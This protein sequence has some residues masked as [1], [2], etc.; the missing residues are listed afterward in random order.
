VSWS[1]R[2]RHRRVTTHDEGG[3]PSLE[4]RP[5]D[6]HVTPARPTAEPDIRAE[7]VHLPGVAAARVSTPEA[8]D[9]AEQ[10]GQDGSGRHGGQ[11]IRAAVAR[12]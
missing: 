6:Q 8:H 10:Q 2:S 3:D 1:D 11:V 4:G 7:A 12:W 5:F 9:V